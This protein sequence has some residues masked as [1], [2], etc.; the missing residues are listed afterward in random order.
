MITFSTIN[1]KFG[2][3]SNKSNHSIT[4]E[5]ITFPRADHWFICSRLEFHKKTTD[6]ICKISDPHDAKNLFKE[7]IKRNPDLL[8]VRLLSKED[9]KNMETLIRMKIEQYPWMKWH[10]MCTGNQMIY[11]D[12]TSKV[13]VN[14]SSLFWG[15]AYICAN[16]EYVDCFWTGENILGGLWMDLRYS[17]IA[18]FYYNECTKSSED[19]INLY[20]KHKETGEIIQRSELTSN[21]DITSA[22]IKKITEKYYGNF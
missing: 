12:V 8:K 5:G 11:E 22:L 7:I 1:D 18:N 3:L 15:A 16:Q 17:L 21:E 2:W 13:N 19:G 10:L 14:D 20:L 4:F 9:V 6:E